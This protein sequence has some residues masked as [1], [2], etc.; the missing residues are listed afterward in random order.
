MRIN[1]NTYTAEVTSDERL[2]VNASSHDPAAIAAESQ[3]AY[4]ATVESDPSATDDDF[5]YLKNNSSKNL[6]VHKITL[7]QD[8]TAAAIQEP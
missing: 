1:G 2:K 5:F 8:P 4:I 3:D 6:H 7:W